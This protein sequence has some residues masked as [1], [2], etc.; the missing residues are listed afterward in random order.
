M[1]DV[2]ALIDAGDVVALRE[3]LGRHP[4]WATA[5]DDEGRSAVMRA[6]YRGGD[7]LA[8]IREAEPPLD[9]FDRI[10]VGDMGELPAP[11]DWT[12]DGFTGLHLAAFSGNAPAAERLLEAGA[13]VDAISRASIARVTP[14]GTA[15]F[16][17][18]TE[19]A[20]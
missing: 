4:E 1:T 16:A 5:R 15:A 9:P 2:F 8:A 14:L 20:R 7:V 11:N 12:S 17:R 3:L 6:G 10:V 13:D 18:A 19:V